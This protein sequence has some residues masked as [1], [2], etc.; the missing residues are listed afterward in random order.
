MTYCRSRLAWAESREWIYDKAP[1]SACACSTLFFLFHSMYSISYTVLLGRVL[2]GFYSPLA[3]LS[4]SALGDFQLTPAPAHG[5]GHG[6]G[7]PTPA[8]ELSRCRAV[9]GLMFHPP[10]SPGNVTGASSRAPFCPPR[11]ADC[12]ASAHPLLQAVAAKANGDV[13]HLGALVLRA[14]GKCG[15]K[16]R[17]LVL[18][19][20]QSQ[21]CLQ[22][23]LI[24]RGRGAELHIAVGRAAIRACLLAQR[25]LE[26]LRARAKRQAVPLVGGSWWLQQQ[27]QHPPY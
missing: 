11:L 16:C 5:V 19:R 1:H 14:P 10:L 23:R 27:R 15:A 22:R 9:P 26:K 21:H 17:V 12:R 8:G 20:A 6:S 25:R 24:G 7:H 13:Q 4:G 3:T 18:A 2:S